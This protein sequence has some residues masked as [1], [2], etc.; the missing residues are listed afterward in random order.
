MSYIQPSLNSHHCQTAD[1]GKLIGF[2]GHYQTLK[3]QLLDVL[4]MCQDRM[5]CH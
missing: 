5:C 2:S 1:I 3:Q 4:P